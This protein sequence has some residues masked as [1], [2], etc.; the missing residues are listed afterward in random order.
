MDPCVVRRRLHRRRPG[1]DQQP[2]QAGRGELHP[3]PI[4]VGSAPRAG[5]VPR[6]GLRGDDRPA[7]PGRRR[8]SRHLSVPQPA[9]HRDAG[10]RAPAVA[11]VRR[12]HRGG[13]D[14]LRRRARLARRRRRLRS[15]FDHRLH[16]GHDRPS[17]G[18]SPLPSD[19]AQR[20]LDRRVDGRRSREP[21]SRPPAVLPR[22]WR[23][24]GHPAGA[25][26]G[27]GTGGDGPVGPGGS[28]E[29]DRA[30]ADHDLQRDPHSFHRRRST[31]PSSLG[32]TSPRFSRAGW[33]AR[34]TRPS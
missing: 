14:R 15:A 16:L 26:R 29:A 2:L 27:R 25:A 11:P 24:H 22:G 28:A 30:R 17:E 20:V 6:H 33:G 4:R 12:L 21:D 32:T 13:G 5:R 1:P 7:D 34:P 31:I 9:P 3:A 18:R 23:F 19:S 8:I 10:R